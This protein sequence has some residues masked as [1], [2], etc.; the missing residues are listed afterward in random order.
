VPF[1][2]IVADVNPERRAFRQPLFD[3]VLNHHPIADPPRLGDLTV[4]HVRGVTAPVAPYELM[5]RTIV[6]R[7]ITV[8]LDFQR[9]RF[10]E[11]SVE[12]WLARYV[13]VLR[14]M[15]AA[16]DQRLSKI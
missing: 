15:I 9:E 7:G 2:R 1:E 4:R 14:A 6:R 8:Q 5:I 12:A 11:P 13:T 16:P 3:L 10:R